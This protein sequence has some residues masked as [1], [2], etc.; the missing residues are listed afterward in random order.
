MTRLDTT[1]Q[2]DRE[3]Q[4]EHDDPRDQHPQRRGLR[5]RHTQVGGGPYVPS[6]NVYPDMLR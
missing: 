4:V 6:D 5:F 3:S 2:K 1:E